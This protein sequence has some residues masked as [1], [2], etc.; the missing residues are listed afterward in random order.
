MDLV[1]YKIFSTKFLI[2][3][4]RSGM[5][6]LDGLNME[7]HKLSPNFSSVHKLESLFEPRR[8]LVI[9]DKDSFL[10]PVESQLGHHG[11]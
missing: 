5:F 9:V 4:L 8:R 1:H 3:I 10:R 2:T 11:L 7:R 6:S